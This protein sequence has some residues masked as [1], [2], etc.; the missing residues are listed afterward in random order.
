MIP[1]LMNQKRKRSIL[2]ATS[3][4]QASTNSE[5]DVPDHVE[6][7][8]EQVKTEAQNLVE[9]TEQVAEQAMPAPFDEVPEDPPVTAPS[10]LAPRS[11]R[12]ASRKA[13]LVIFLEE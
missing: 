11:T 9:Q 2:A 4:N 10:V 12:V 8:K 5:I 13:K 7:E 6:T 1:P 3:D